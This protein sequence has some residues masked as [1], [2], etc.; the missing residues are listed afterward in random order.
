MCFSATASFT[1]SATLARSEHRNE[2]LFASIPLLFALHQ[3][4]EGAVWLGLS[5]DHALGGLRPWGFL[6]MLYAQGLLTLLIPLGIW[7]IEPGRGRRLLILPFLAI[8]AGLTLYQLWALLK[9]PTAIY[10]EGHSVVYR[11]PGTNHLLIAA[12]YVFATCGSLFFSGYRYIIALGAVNLI[13]V[14]VVLWLKHYAFT[15]V[16]C[17]YAAVVSILI[18]FHFNRRRVVERRGRV[19]QH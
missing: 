9:F 11:N 7:L 17:A 8:G 10:V 16:W 13:G 15:S 2:W 19:L 5:G 4:A 12:L 1:S 3:F 6:Y 14:L 18:Y